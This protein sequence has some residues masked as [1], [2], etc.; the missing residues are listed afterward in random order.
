MPYR[1]EV[2]FG[3]VALGLPWDVSEK[4]SQGKLEAVWVEHLDECHLH[5]LRGAIRKGGIPAI[6]FQHTEH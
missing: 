4:Q 2:V 3:V 6:H 5:Q 1:Q